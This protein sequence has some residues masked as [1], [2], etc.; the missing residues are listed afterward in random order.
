MKALRLAAGFTL[1]LALAGCGKSEKATPATTA[2]SGSTAPATSLKAPDTT[3]A[4]PSTTQDTAPASVMPDVVGKKLDVALSDLK[5]AGFKSK[6]EYTGGGTFGVQV[7][8]NWTVCAQSPAAGE[9]LTNPRLTIERSCDGGASKSTST[10]TEPEQ[11]LTPATNTDL[12]ELLAGNHVCDDTVE[13]FA[14]TYRGKTLEFDGNIVYMELYGD[15]KT[16][17]D[18]LLNGGNFGDR[19]NGPNFKFEDV[20]ILDLGITGTNAPET[21]GKGDNVHVAAKVQAF[22]RTQCLFFLDPVSTVVR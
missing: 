14:S 9:A 19:Y 3:A 5:S 8:S 10:T 15:K 1:V 22:N 18:I 6:P 2:G 17:Y 16:R 4:S 13:R 21:I 7:E 12:A 11:N 20:G